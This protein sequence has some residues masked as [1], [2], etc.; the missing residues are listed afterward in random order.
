MWYIYHVT[1]L[2]YD[3]PSYCYVLDYPFINQIF[4]FSFPSSHF[5]QVSVLLSLAITPV[6]TPSITE[7]LSPKLHYHTP[8]PPAHLH[9]TYLLTPHY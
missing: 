8:L 7:S 4:H 2:G 9:Q 1:G 5:V 6:T 3:F